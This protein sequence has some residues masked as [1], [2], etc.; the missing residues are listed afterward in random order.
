MGNI[1][2][3]YVNISDQAQIVS[4]RKFQGTNPKIFVILD[5]MSFKLKRRDFFQQNAI[6]TDRQIALKAIKLSYQVNWKMISNSWYHI[7]STFRSC[8]KESRDGI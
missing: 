3:G 1:A 8:K 5:Q 4:D 7:Y 2:I 6:H